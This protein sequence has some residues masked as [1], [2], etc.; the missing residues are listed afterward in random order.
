MSDFWWLVALWFVLVLLGTVNWQRLWGSLHVEGS[1]GSVEGLIGPGRLL[2][3]A[4]A[5]PQPGSRVEIVTSADSV[6]A[7]VASRIRRRDDTWAEL[8]VASSS[9][10]ESL[11]QGRT[12]S[13]RTAQTDSS[14]VGIVEEGSSVDVLRFVAVRRLHVG[15]VVGV[16]DSG[17]TVLFQISR[18]RVERKSINGGAQLVTVA[19]AVQLGAFAVDTCRL[20]KNRWVVPAGAIVRE[21]DAAPVVDDVPEHLFRLGTVLYTQIPVYLDLAMLCEGHT[22]VLGMTKMGKSTLTHRLSAAIAADRRTVVLDATGEYAKKKGVVQF[23]KSVPW[24]EPSLTVLEPPDGT[25]RPDYALKCVDKLMEIASEEYNVGDPTPRVL[26]FEEAHDF[27]PEPASLGFNAPGRDSSYSLGLRM[28]QVRKYGMSFLLVSQRTAVVSKSALS[29]CE[30][31]IV[32]RSV[33]RT[34]LDYLEDLSGTDVRSVI[35]TLKQGEAV[36]F[37]PAVS[38]DGAVAVKVDLAT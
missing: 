37:G 21:V 38:A 9:K 1:I 2:V 22:S 16:D 20:T 17:E 8:V 10:A 33:D 7:V 19:E 5:V 31:L 36:V 35:P 34:G 13:L 32:F 27:F 3:S 25:V 23:D 12:I 24:H 4:P 6:S 14:F 29:Q 30:N 15:A 26:V 28:M 11:L 18:A